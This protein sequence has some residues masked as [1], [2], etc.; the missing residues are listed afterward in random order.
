MKRQHDLRKPIDNGSREAVQTSALMNDL[1]RMVGIIDD[2]IAREEKEAGVFDRSSPAYPL[3]AKMLRARRDNLAK[4]IAL[5]ER[6]LATL[7]QRTDRMMFGDAQ[8]A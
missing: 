3:L 2:D 4:T 8:Q 1:D 7:L 6:R 5:L